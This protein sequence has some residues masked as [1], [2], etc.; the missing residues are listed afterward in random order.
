MTSS[1]AINDTQHHNG[2]KR[3]QVNQWL[4]AVLLVTTWVACNQL[5]IWSR[6][7]FLVAYAGAPRVVLWSQIEEKE[8]LT[9]L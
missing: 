3:W 6:N 7:K 2:D 8:R 5:L 9:F 4:I 1:P